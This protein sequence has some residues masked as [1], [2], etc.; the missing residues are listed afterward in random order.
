MYSTYLLSGAA[1]QP[2][3]QAGSNTRGGRYEHPQTLSTTIDS[4]VVPLTP[5]NDSILVLRQSLAIEVQPES[6]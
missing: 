4:P 6:V 2:A 5:S 1:I 3:N